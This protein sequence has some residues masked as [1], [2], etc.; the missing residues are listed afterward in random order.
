MAEKE[1]IKTP[2][3]EEEEPEE[4]KEIDYKGLLDK[5]TKD[6]KLKDEQIEQLKAKV[7]AMERAEEKPTILAQKEAE[8]KLKSMVK[9]MVKEEMTSEEIEAE[10][11]EDIEEQAAREQGIPEEKIEEKAEEETPEETPEEG[12]EED[13]DLM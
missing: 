10:I 8:L 6:A 13:P 12:K 4:L 7:A 1:F 2:E 3:K 11:Q 5:V 9:E